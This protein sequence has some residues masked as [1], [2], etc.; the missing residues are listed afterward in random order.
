MKVGTIALLHLD[1]VPGAVA[2][3]QAMV[4]E[5]VTRAASSGARWIV[6]PELVSCGLQFPQLLGTDWIRPQPDVWMTRFCRL[7]RKLGVTV[8]FAAPERE[9]NR[10]YNSVFVIGPRGDILGKHQK[11]NTK[12]DS[13]SWSS[14]G[15]RAQPVRCDGITVGL[16]VC[17]D[18]FT[19]GIAG[20]LKRSGAQLLISPS[21]WGPGLHGPN[22]EWEDRSRETGVPLIVCNRTGTDRTLDFRK[23]QSLVVKNGE[24]LLTHSSERSAVLTLDWDFSAMA[25]MTA[26]F[27]MMPLSN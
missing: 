25:P 5:A 26:A 7:V 22:G 17:A 1:I 10:L 21:S 6:T 8:F 3:N 27:Q 20:S 15:D 9:G 2:R 4:A 16:L 19:P 14:P 23:A 13:L 12:S 11:I 18:A 24:R